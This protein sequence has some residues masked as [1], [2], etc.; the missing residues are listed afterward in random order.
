M[1]AHFSVFILV[2][3]SMGALHCSDDVEVAPTTSSTT[4]DT[5]GSG[6]AGGQ[7]PSCSV[8]LIY[9][10]AAGDLDAFP[11]DYFT[12]DDASS[13]TGLRVHT[14]VGD[15]I[16]LPPEASSFKQVFADLSSLDGFGTTAELVVQFTGP[17]D[18]DTIPSPGA[19]ADK[20]ASIHLLAMPEGAAASLLPFEYELVAEADGDPRTTLI[21]APL[22]PLE[23]KTR[24]ALVLSKAVRAEEGCIAPSEAMKQLLTSTA[25]EA[26]FTRLDGRYEQLASALSELGSD[27]ELAQAVAALVFTTQHTVEDSAVIAADIR[28]SSYEYKSAGACQDGVDYLSC[29]GE[30]V[31][32]D[33]RVDGHEI[34]ET[35]LT[36]QASYTLKVVTYLPKMGS[37]PFPTI[38]FGHGLGGDRTQAEGLAEVAAPLGF[39]TIAIDAVK[40]GD[41]PDQA[42]SILPAADIRAF[43]GMSLT[44]VDGIALR[45]N[46]RQSTYDKLQL[47]EMLRPGVDVDGDNTADVDLDR[48]M[49]LGVSLGGVM[50]PELLAFAPEVDVALPI[51]PGARVVGII[52]DGEQFEI[53][54]N[55][56]KGMATDGQV[57]RFFP[58]LQTIVDR[59]DAG[60]YLRHVVSNR[61]KGFDSQRP[62]VLMQMVLED[63]TVPNSTNSF[64]A[65]GLG[66]PHVGPELLALGVIPH[67]PSLPISGNVDASHTG[68]VFQFDVV[69]D[70]AGPDTKQASHGN[71]A[72]NP[73]ALEQSLHFIDTFYD[74]GVSEIIDPYVTLGI[75]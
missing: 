40:H 8:E 53:V 39:A 47:I 9:D 68:G 4:T 44:G 45:D 60:A 54:I 56:L 64:F 30:L 51:V 33:Y 52:K 74:K 16:V 12:V 71:V 1:R 65:R 59:G 20:S 58:L 27:V 25:T 21:I 10:P 55:L 63:D 22:V 66:L 7:A 62:Q 49:Y 23:P 37:A 46:W 29:S 70:G 50:A 34:D 38:L 75:K 13:L 2:A 67:E 14:V 31:A 6:G 41:H 32:N 35:K 26:A 5:G 11:D 57:A 48:F 28:K 24:H 73:V 18:A 3:V 43:F 72:G 15:N 69:F 42:D 17:L 61:L 19:S 36:P